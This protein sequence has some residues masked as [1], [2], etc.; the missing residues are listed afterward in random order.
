[1]I[2]NGNGNGKNNTFM[3]VTREQLPLNGDGQLPRPRHR[4]H[5]DVGLGHAARQ[6]LLRR[7]LQERLDDAA[8]PPRVHDADSQ[9]SAIV[10]LRRGALD[11]V[12]RHGSYCCCVA[13]SE[14]YPDWWVGG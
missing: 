5:D 10:L 14:Q 8:I 3:Y 13:S 9:A 1:M 4:L 11:G 7:P 2:G 12:R 6:Q